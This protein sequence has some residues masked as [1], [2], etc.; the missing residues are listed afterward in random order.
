MTAVNPSRSS[1]D[2][3]QVLNRSDVKQLRKR[4]R[5]HIE[6]GAVT[7]NY[8]GDKSQTIAILQIVLATEIVCVLRYTAHSILAEGI[9]SE[10]VA[11]EFKEHADDERRHALLAAQRI[12]QLGG[13]PDFDPSTL[14][15]RSATS[16]Q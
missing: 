1:A 10:S 8:Q 15:S 16:I 13:D 7:K 2:F 6:K 14:T 5:E 11:A 12:D 9:T 4:A 3:M